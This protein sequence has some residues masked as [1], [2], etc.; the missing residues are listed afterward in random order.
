MIFLVKIRGFLF[1][2]VSRQTT[3]SRH[4]GGDSGGYLGE[5]SSKFLHLEGCQ[6]DLRKHHEKLQL[7]PFPDPDQ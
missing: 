2:L 5:K 1:Q 6:N 7:H 3:K 4:F